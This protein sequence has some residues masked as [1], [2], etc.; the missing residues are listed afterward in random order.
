MKKDIFLAFCVFSLFACQSADTQNITLMSNDT[1]EIIS[2]SLNN[3]EFLK[4][5]LDIDTLYF[6]R[7]K[8]F[9]QSFLKAESRFKISSLPDNSQSRMANIGLSYPYDGRQRLSVFKFEHID[10][11]LNVQMYEQGS[12]LFYKTN[13]IK[14]NGNWLIVKQRTYSGGRLD[15]YEFEDEQWYLD[16]KKKIKPHKAMFPPPEPKTINS[17]IKDDAN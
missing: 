4:E 15:K 6:L 8:L 3:K 12:N 7:N 1:A 13:L 17:D 5:N 11:T 9:N 14:R 16:L 2:V 10:D